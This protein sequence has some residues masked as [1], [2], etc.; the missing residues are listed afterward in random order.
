MK[1]DPSRKLDPETMLAVAKARERQ[2][3]RLVSYSIALAILVLGLGVL[4]WFF[5]PEDPP[6]FT[7][8]AYDAVAVPAES[9]TLY[10]RLEPENKPRPLK[11][12]SR[13]V[14]FQITTTQR[15]ETLATDEH[16]TSA[17]EFQAPAANAPLEFRVRHQHKDEPKRVA[18]DQGRV[19]V[20]PAKTKLLVVDVDHALA[21]GV[22]ALANAGGAAPALHDGAAA[23]LRTLS[24]KYKIVYLSA[25]AYQPSSYKKLRTWLR[26]VQLPDGPL[27]SPPMPVVSD[28]R[29]G[30]F[31]D[32]IAALRKRFSEPAIG[33][34]GRAVEAR[35]YLNAGW[36][37][38][39]IGDADALP[40]GAS[41]VTAWTELPKE[42]GP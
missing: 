23:S 13:D 28:N 9:I 33:V 32:Q 3:R 30:F 4:G 1:R 24:S 15:A 27:L 31:I 14:L 34:A 21:D 39:V 12:G 19:F 10:A 41:T 16:G 26:Q 5:W 36:K 17:L 38:V 22:D 18:S 42:L 8:T 37:A 6:R 35:I 29:H 25:A 2:E 40:A 7:I 11:L 20:W